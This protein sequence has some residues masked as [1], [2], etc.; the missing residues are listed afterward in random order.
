[1]L[2]STLSLPVS[3]QVL[4]RKI[5]LIRNILPINLHRGIVLILNMKYNYK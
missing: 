5:L 4:T 2:R 3:S 1:M